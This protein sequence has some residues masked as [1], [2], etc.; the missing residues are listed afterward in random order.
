MYCCH[1]EYGK[2]TELKNSKGNFDTPGILSSQ[3][4]E[5]VKWWERSILDAF[6]VIKSN[7]EINYIICTDP[8]T[9]CRDVHG[10]NQYINRRW[11]VCET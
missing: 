6:C 11:P 2:I 1:P 5:K 4:I 10:N 9:N 3:A 8:S 7:P